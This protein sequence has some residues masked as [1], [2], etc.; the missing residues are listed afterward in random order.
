MLFEQ[1]NLTIIFSGMYS[2][3]RIAKKKKTL[4]F[5]RNMLVI[6]PVLLFWNYLIYCSVV[7]NQDFEFKRKK[8][9]YE[10]KEIKS[11]LNLKEK[12]Q[13]ELTIFYFLLFNMYFLT[14][15]TEKT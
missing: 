9:K 11:L 1:G 12:Y 13:Y 10:I 6:I 2:L 3:N 8:Y 7:W 14:Q 4:S 5:T 15:P